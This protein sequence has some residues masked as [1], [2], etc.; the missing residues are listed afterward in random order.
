[1]KEPNGALML[2]IFQVLYKKAN[3]VHN[4]EVRLWSNCINLY[5]PREEMLNKLRVIPRVLRVFI[6]QPR[7][8]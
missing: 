1:M 6:V 8:L 2:Y 5:N 4:Y 3:K 7:R